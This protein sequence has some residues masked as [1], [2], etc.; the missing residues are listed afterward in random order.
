M[1]CDG[2]KATKD[3]DLLPGENAPR[4]LDA[5]RTLPVIDKAELH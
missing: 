4:F 1:L 5:F 3:V 2:A